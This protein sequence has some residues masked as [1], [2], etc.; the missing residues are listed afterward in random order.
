VEVYEQSV[1]VSDSPTMYMTTSSRG[2]DIAPVPVARGG[3][4]LVK[5]VIKAVNNF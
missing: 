2:G 4:E 3:E 5:D 1:D